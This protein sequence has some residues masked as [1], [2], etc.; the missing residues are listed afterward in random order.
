MA[1]AAPQ[2]GGA[3]QQVQAQRHGGIGEEA[4]V[5][6]QPGQI[7]AGQIGQRHGGRRPVAD[8]QQAA[9]QGEKAEPAAEEQ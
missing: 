2:A 8:Q 5:V 1:A 3:Q 6:G 4:E 9:G 7:Q